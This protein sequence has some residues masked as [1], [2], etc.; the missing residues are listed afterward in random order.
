[1]MSSPV[2]TLHVEQ[3]Y[4]DVYMWSLYVTASCTEQLCA[5]V[6]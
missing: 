6:T 5:G 4:D 3:L 1:M 2:M